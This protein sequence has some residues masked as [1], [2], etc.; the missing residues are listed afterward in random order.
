MKCL[1][2]SEKPMLQVNLSQKEKA[3]L[4]NFFR[5]D[6]SGNGIH[7]LIVLKSSEG[8][9]PPQIARNLKVHDHTVRTWI[10]RYKSMGVEGLRRNYPPGRSRELR[11]NVKEVMEEALEI[12]PYEKGYPVALWTTLLLADWMHKEKGLQASQDTI[13]RALREKGYRY[14][15][16]QLTVPQKAPT[17]QEKKRAVENMITRMKADMKNQ[18]YEVFALDESH[19]SNEPYV[20]S[21]WKKKL[22]TETSANQGQEGTHHN[23]WVLE[24]ADKKVLLEERLK[25]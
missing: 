14:K 5:Y 6:N 25:R 15:R 8:M 4:Q 20:V 21:G 13:E 11:E 9:S 1:Y 7:A 16:S 23:I 10:K 22:W 3:V 12:S 24:F 2:L 18:D 19:F 17:K